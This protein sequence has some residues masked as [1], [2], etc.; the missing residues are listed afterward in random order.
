MKPNFY[1]YLWVYESFAVAN[2]S[3]HDCPHMSL[4]YY[5]PY[6]RHLDTKNQC[7]FFVNCKIKSYRITLVHST[8][9][10]YLT[11]TVFTTLT[12]PQPSWPVLSSLLCCSYT[13]CYQWLSVKGHKV[14]ST[15]QY[16][17][18]MYI[19][20]I[21]IWLIFILTI[22][23][24]VIFILHVKDHFKNIKYLWFCLKLFL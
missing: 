8:K 23:E 24:I 9:Q 6:N 11:A 20:Q 22:I 5:F 4:V 17:V 15:F 3:C 13:W 16:T 10:E 1:S 21:D 19:Y 14:T 12:L 2:F 18:K 7:I